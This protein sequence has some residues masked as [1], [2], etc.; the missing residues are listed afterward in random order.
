MKADLQAR[1]RAR[2]FAALDLLAGD[3]DAFGIALS[4]GGDSVALLHLAK[5]W[6]EARGIRLAAATVDHGLRAES[7]A[8]AMTAAR[9][10]H[11]QGIAHHTLI[12]RGGQSQPGNLMANA[13]EARLRLLAGWARDQGL[14]A[15]ALGHTRDDL[16]ET[17][18]MRLARGAGID[19]LAPMAPRRE[20]Q[21]IRWLR[22]LL[23]LGRAELRD[24]LRSAGIGWID[25]PSNENDR[26]ERVRI[27]QAMASLGLDPALIALSASHLGHARDALNAALRPLLDT[28]SARAGALR[29]NRAAFDAA[30][31]EQRRRLLLAALRFVTGRG[32][33]P[34]RA[35]VEHAMTALIR[36][37]RT[38]L[39]GA[40]LDPG[41]EL[42]IHREPAATR[43]GAIGKIWDDRWR[44]EG[45]QPGDSV[46]ALG[47]DVACFD[48]RGAG[49]SHLEAQALPAVL[50]GKILLAPAI[51]AQ[52]GL[53]AQALRDI[54]DFRQILLGH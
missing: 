23:D 1:L 28:A 54:T 40:V 32:Y 42:L 39:D 34:R 31:P 9:A 20:A 36:G 49:F 44:I 17:L 37:S 4:G 5:D 11:E 51:R 35:G 25:D 46:R 19:G 29:L 33:P 14:H 38:T 53:T 7:A 21:G 50:R 43:P 10:S 45:L 8:E 41:P 26:Y 47:P 24:W 30:P 6:A 16:A 13:R 48:W 18:L 27:R 3:L 22:P 52:A 15:V 12:W 2:A